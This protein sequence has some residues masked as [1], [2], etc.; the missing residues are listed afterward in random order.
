[1]AANTTNRAVTLLFAC[2]GRR[3]ELL[4]AF[5]RA[6]HRLGIDL[7]I[8]GADASP[9]APAAHL[10]DLS[11]RV[12]RAGDD[13]YIPALLDIVRQHRVDLLIPLIDSDLP[14]LSLSRE[15]FA[16]CGCEVLISSPEAVGICRDKMATYQFLIRYHLP[17][18]ET[19]LYDA[20]RH[21]QYRSF[22]YFLKPRYGSAAESNF[23]VHTSDELRVLASRVPE[24]IIQTY[25]EGTEHTLDVYVCPRGQVRCVVPRRRLAVRGGEVSKS[26][27]VRDPAVIDVGRRVAQHLTGARGVITIQCMVRPDGDVR[28]IEIN[29]RL[30]GGVPLAIFAGADFPLWLLQEHIGQTPDYR[31]D[32]YTD[33]VQMLRF[34][35][36]IFVFPDGRCVDGR[37]LR[38]SP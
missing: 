32:A 30:G 21:E 28:V 4:E 13:D 17:T 36:S 12:P 15:R 19:W 35:Q 3:V 26:Q 27:I 37:N 20:R 22:P 34:D 14:V 6:A 25:I 7:R 38:P 11:V 10:C 2:V 33:G 29:P 23:L 5:R 16:E 31:D 8:I 9:T 18:P 1:M 24:P